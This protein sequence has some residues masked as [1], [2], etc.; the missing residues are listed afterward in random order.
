MNL[1]IIG[2]PADFAETLTS[3][4]ADY[5]LALSSEAVNRLVDYYDLINLWNPRLHLVATCAP[6]EFARRHI[7]ESLYAISH[8]PPHALLIDV[9]AGAG[10][11]SI[12][13]L[14]A[15]PDVRGELIEASTK[16]SVF[17]R[18]AVRKLNLSGAAT[19]VNARY[20]SLAAPT[21][22]ALTCRALDD[23]PR[24]LPRLLEWS[25]SVSRLL[26]FGGASLAARLDESTRYESYL[27]PNSERR[28]LFVIKTTRADEK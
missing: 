25:A 21:A 11:P 7:L 24:A 3:E 26:L 18:E 13:C 19:I 2:R 5:N 1:R 4:A 23:F 16:K 27:L 28:Y 10:L 15:R 8:L 12:P 20:E 17:L 14:I 22:D 9:G 6:G